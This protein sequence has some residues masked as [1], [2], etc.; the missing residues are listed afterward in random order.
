MDHPIEDPRHVLVR[1]L[2]D[3]YDR[4]E[5]AVIRGQDVEAWESFWLGLLAEYET[6]CDHLAPP[7]RAEAA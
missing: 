2:D 1:R 3:G 6:V 4:I 7:E 5:H